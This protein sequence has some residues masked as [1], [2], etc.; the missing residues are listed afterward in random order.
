[1]DPSLCSFYSYTITRT[2]VPKDECGNYG[3]PCVQVITVDDTTPPSISCPAD[4]TLFSDANCNVD[5]D[6]AQIGMPTNVGDNCDPDP[7]VDFTDDS[8]FGNPINVQMNH[9]QGYYFEVDV[10]GLD[11]FSASDL[12]R[13]DME[14]LTNQGKGNVEFILIAPSGDGIVLVGPYCSGG[15]CEVA[16]ETVYSPSFFPE[17]SGNTI[18]NNNNF[19]A[20]G[21]GSFRPNGGTSANV[22]VGFNGNYRSSFEE[23]TGPMNGQWVLY[24]KK[25]G[26]ATGTVSFNG[27]CLAPI[28]CAGSDVIV[29]TWTA[30]DACG[31]TSTCQQVISILD[32][33]PPE[34]SAAA[35]PAD[36]T[37]ECDEPIPPVPD[38]T[39]STTDNCD[40]APTVTFTETSTQG[41]NPTLCS[42][43][44]YTITRTWIPRDDCGN[45]G[46]PCVQ[47]ITIEDTTPPEISTA[48]CPADIT[49]ECDETIP[50]APDLTASTTDNCDPSPTVTFTETSTQG[51]DPE[52]CDYYSYTI[53]RSWTPKDACGNYGTPCVQ[54]ITIEDTTP[55][56]ISAA[57]C[58]ADITLECDEE[59][60]AAPDLTA[61]TSDNCD[62]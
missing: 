47:L 31:N 27:F 44:S 49:L 6:P 52:E 43:Y 1:D 34:I 57:D 28:S 5:T 60:P 13:V 59:I 8:C 2:W 23:L 54:L 42:Y 24:G 9:G 40:P 4:V 33:I 26:T 35:C 30:T 21:A 17:S 50:D 41:D 7:Q 55:P 61:S 20:P 48:D 25:D 53:T 19:I 16:A 3:T 56:E 22:I 12:S 18:W 62:A 32:I 45:F 51:D 14:F 11:G 58:P 15:F 39:A 37:L 29:R 46:A 38:L 36:V 10:S